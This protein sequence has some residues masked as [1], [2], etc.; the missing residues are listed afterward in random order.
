MSYLE[1]LVLG[2][3]S[4]SVAFTMILVGGCGSTVYRDSEEVVIGPGH[5]IPN[6]FG[7][8]VS[9]RNIGNEFITLNSDWK[10]P[11]E[12]GSH[13]IGN[14]DYLEVLEVH[15][16]RKWIR[17]KIRSRVSSSLGDAWTF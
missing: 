1:T 9:L 11:A 7:P 14:H 15:D 2:S 3:R 13:H 6:D 10:V 5:S 17:A 16:Q 8:S 12:P 4:F